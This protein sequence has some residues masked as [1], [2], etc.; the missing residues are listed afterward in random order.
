MLRIEMQKLK[1]IVYMRKKYSLFLL[2]IFMFLCYIA[3]QFAGRK[4]KMNITQET[5]MQ[6]K[7]KAL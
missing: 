7:G 3:K 4:G 5:L 6:A 2:Y 1:R